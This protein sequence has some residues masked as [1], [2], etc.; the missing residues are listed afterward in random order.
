MWIAAVS[1]PLLIIAAFVVLSATSRRPKNLGVRDGRLPDCPSSPNCVST[2]ENRENQRMDPIRL[3]IDSSDAMDVLKQ[4]VSTLPRTQIINAGED[5]LHVEFT[6]ALFRFVDDVEFFIDRDRGE[7]HFRSA[8]RAGHS[9]LGVNRNRMQ[10]IVDQ[11]REAAA[12]TSR[13]SRTQNASDTA[14][15]PAPKTDR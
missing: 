12:D 13:I 5:Y 11:F 8:S 15:Q 3:T 4:V 7:I 14:R 2:Q 6:S 10:S 9:D 1:V